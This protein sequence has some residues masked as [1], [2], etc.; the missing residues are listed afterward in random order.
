M[1]VTDNVRYSCLAYPVAG[2]RRDLT[3]QVSPEDR[4]AFPEVQA[5]LMEESL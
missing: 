3:L 5:A 1:L 4:K 2:R